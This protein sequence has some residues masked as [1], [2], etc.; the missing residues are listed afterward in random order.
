MNT[1]PDSGSSNPASCSAGIT[2]PDEAIDSL[3]KGNDRFIRGEMQ[4]HD[5]RAAQGRGANG[6]R[7]LAA[8]LRCADSRIAPELVFDRTIGDLFVCGV[9]GNTPTPEIIASLEYCVAELE[10]P[11]VVIMGHSQ[12]GAVEA[13]IKH[14]HDPSGQPGPLHGVL[15]DIL[16]ACIEARGSEDHL[17]RAVELNVLN[18]VKRV[19]DESTVISEAVDAGTCKVVGGVCDLASG[20]FTL[21]T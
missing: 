3:L 10:C 4:D 1:S 13:A 6:Q 11:L 7:P 18:A 21:L 9:A 12:C 15:A 2:S 8:F 17:A 19:M 5:H 20:R 16:P 14:E